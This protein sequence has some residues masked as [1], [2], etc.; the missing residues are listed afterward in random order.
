MK[1]KQETQQFNMTYAQL[2]QLGDKAVILI[3]R[4]TAE[5]AT[6]GVDAA[7]KTFI[8]NK[9][10]DLKDMPTDEELEATVTDLTEK[11]DDKAEEVKVAVRGIMVRAKNAFG[12]QTGNFRRFGSK[13]MD[14]MTDGQLYRCGKRVAR[15]AETFLADLAPKG[16]TQAIIDAL[17]TTNNQFDDKIDL[18]DDAK[19]QRDIATAARIRLGNNLYAKIAEVCDY[20]KEYWAT[21][22]EA[23][24]NDYVIYDVP[25]APPVPPVNP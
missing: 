24:Y 18:Q 23:K 6:F 20:G 21:R 2:M 3:T 17:K 13:G 9:T 10:Q 12:E 1:K 11:K 8:A 7:T 16:L 4:D 14:E 25:P 15:V 19:R 5:L 22:N